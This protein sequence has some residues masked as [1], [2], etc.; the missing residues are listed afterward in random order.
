MDGYL[1]SLHRWCPAFV[2]I[3]LHFSWCRNHLEQRP[4]PNKSNLS[5][6]RGRWG[7]KGGRFISSSALPIIF[8]SF[9]ITQYT[10]AA[11]VKR[12]HIR[13]GQSSSALS[14]AQCVHSDVWGGEVTTTDFTASLT[15]FSL[16]PSLIIQGYEE[17]R[18]NAFVWSLCLSS[19]HTK[20]NPV[21]IKLSSS[22]LKND[23]TD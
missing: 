10:I 23:S 16:H 3:S 21:K 15:S 12:E 18:L 19:W 11:T 9:Q 14:A 17:K 7:R 4:S 6:P 13:K 8:R 2:K 22:L 1:M 20:K 5:S